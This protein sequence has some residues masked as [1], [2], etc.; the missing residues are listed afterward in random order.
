MKDEEKYIRLLGMQLMAAKVKLAAVLV[1]AAAVAIAVVVWL[2]RGD[3]IG[4]SHT[5][6]ID[7]TPVEVERIRSI[8]EW[9][10]LAVSDEEIVD[11]V[12]HRLLGS[13]DEL[14]RIYYGTLRLG[15]DLRDAADD[16]ISTDGDTLVVKLPPV[17]LLDEHFIDEARTR[18]FYE[19][20]TW[21]AAARAALTRKAE[22]MM[23]QRCL[24]ADNLHSAGQNAVEQFGQMMRSMGYEYVRVEIQPRNNKK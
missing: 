2:T 4:I 8:G 21:S 16:W 14:S 12:R 11:T 15:I 22:A 23:R 3:T 13:D 7:I 1:A 6:K 20:G 18:S 19:D 9:E 24:T 17:K 10:F 5:S